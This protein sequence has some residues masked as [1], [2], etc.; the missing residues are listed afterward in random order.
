MITLLPAFKYN[1]YEERILK[2]LSLAYRILTTKQIAAFSGISYN[3]VKN[4]LDKLTKDGEITKSRKGNRIYW[5]I[6]KNEGENE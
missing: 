3:T 1:L 5:G 2:T 4:Y 6:I